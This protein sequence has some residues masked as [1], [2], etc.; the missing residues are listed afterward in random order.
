VANSSSSVMAA[1]AKSTVGSLAMAGRAV[2]STSRNRKKL[3][4]RQK[5]EADR[6]RLVMEV[7]RRLAKSNQHLSITRALALAKTL[8]NKTLPSLMKI[9]LKRGA[10][11]EDVL[12]RVQDPSNFPISVPFSGGDE[13]SFTPSQALIALIISMMS[14][15]M[16]ASTTAVEGI[17]KELHALKVDKVRL[18]AVRANAHEGKICDAYES[19]N[20]SRDLQVG[21][22]SAFSCCPRGGARY[23]GPHARKFCSHCLLRVP[24]PTYLFLFGY[25]MF[26]CSHLP[27]TFMHLGPE[28]IM[29]RTPQKLII[30]A[31]TQH[32]CQWVAGACLPRCTRVRRHAKPKNFV[33][34]SRIDLAQRVSCGCGGHHNNGTAHANASPASLCGE[35]LL[36]NASIST[37]VQSLRKSGQE[38]LEGDA[39]AWWAKNTFLGDSSALQVLGSFDGT[40][41][42]WSLGDARFWLSVMVYTTV[43]IMLRFGIPRDSFP[44]ADSTMLGTIGAFLTFFLVFCAALSSR[45]CQ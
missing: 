18:R 40:V 29:W 27:V 30:D 37:F 14:K 2:A 19:P 3:R 39:P 16:T 43:R 44:Q 24:T 22:L 6:R 41:L 1:A 15:E 10:D 21:A 25:N 7:V 11:L 8:D 4:E 13:A 9:A 45:F 32:K 26:L 33:E 42:P 38:K 5:A 23:F 34:L 12:L 31:E 35:S 17:E 20:E 28:V 36:L